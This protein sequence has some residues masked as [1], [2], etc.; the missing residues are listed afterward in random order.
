M[1]YR[2]EKP[3]AEL[4][5]ILQKVSLIVMIIPSFVLTTGRPQEITSID[6]DVKTKYNQYN[7]VKTNLSQLQKK[8][9]YAPS[10]FY[11][12]AID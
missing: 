10:H 2:A 11:V 8:Q 6:N 5:G 12:W 1:K 7:Q 9:T 3:L 4:I